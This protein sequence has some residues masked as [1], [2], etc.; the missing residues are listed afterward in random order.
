MLWNV[1]IPAMSTLAGTDIIMINEIRNH[2][3]HAYIQYV[4]DQIKYASIEY[5]R[6]VQPGA[7]QYSARSSVKDKLKLLKAAG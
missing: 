7:E 3:W 5:K 6:D 2:P 4:L 1:N